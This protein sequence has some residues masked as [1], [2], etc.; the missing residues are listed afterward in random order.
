ML[1]AGKDGVDKSRFEGE[2]WTPNEDGFHHASSP[3]SIEFP[4]DKDGVSRICVVRATLAEKRNQK[5]LSKKLNEMLKTKP[6][7]QSESQIWMVSTASGTRGIQFYPDKSSDQPQVR[8]IGA[9]F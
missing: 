7:K 6:L 5:K 2:A 4:V 3:I 8:L 9:A 1:S